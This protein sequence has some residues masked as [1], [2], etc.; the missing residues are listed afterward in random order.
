[1]G[2]GILLWT[3]DEP[4]ISSGTVLPVYIRSNIDHVWVVGVPDTAKINN[5][6][7]K[8]EVPLSLFEFVGSKRK[9]VKR[10]VEFAQY[11]SVYAENM[12]D[13]LPIRDDPDNGSR[14]VYRLRPGEI[15]KILEKAEGNP[16]I[17]TTG[18]PLPGD[19]YL[20]L[21][22][23]GV[24]G[25]CFSY[26]LKL[27]DHHEG[28]ILAAQS[29]RR[30]MT[31]DS[32][33]EMVLSKTWSPEYYQQMINS[34][35]VNISEFQKKY[36]FDPGQDTGIAEIYTPDIEMDFIYESIYPDGERAWR[37]EGTNLQM[38]LRTNTTL[39]VQYIDGSGSRRT[40]LFSSLSADVDDIIVQE[41]QRR[42]TQLKNIYNQGPS[43]T[44]NN[45][46][47][48]TLT[49]SGNFTW[50][51][52]DLL[53][54]HLIP[55]ESSGRGRIYMDLFISTTLAERYLGAFTLRLTD[56]TPNKNIFFMYSLDNQ[57]LRL[58]VVPDYGIEDITV[59]RR[60]STPM[61]LYF[62]RDSS[63]SPGTAP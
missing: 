29:S 35:R 6:A 57:G 38:S 48:I 10:A 17:S 14:R 43:F 7:D 52:F 45:Y 3:N 18:D 24:R 33:L 32:D 59:T 42:E 49:G 13:G 39:A 8:I 2:Y 31:L 37:F 22:N 44:S 47:T 36:H 51:D 26:R 46:G 56:V 41:N 23:D 30:E 62:F 55:S 1:M 12:Q 40:L 5:N 63:A 21:T 28:P 50:T 61:V 60:A 4:H 34:R 53:V 11:A 58:E 54:P 19:W 27:F 25:Y 20:V 15:I 16:P 9:A